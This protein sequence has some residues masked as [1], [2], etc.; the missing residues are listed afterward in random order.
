ML[1]CVASETEVIVIR[2]AKKLKRCLIALRKDLA[3][4]VFC[5][6]Q[7]LGLDCE[8]KPERRKTKS[9]PKPERSPVSV[10]QLSGPTLTL[11]I[12]T[13][14][15]FPEKKKDL[16]LSSLSELFLDDHV[17]KVGNCVAHDVKRLWID[18]ALT[19]RGF[20]DLNLLW[21][22]IWWQKIRVP[23]KANT[24]RSH[25]SLADMGKEY[26]DMTWPKKES[27]P[28]LSDWSV[29]VLSQ[30]QIM[31]AAAD[32]FASRKCFFAFCEHDVLPRYSRQELAQWLQENKG[33]NVGEQLKPLTS[34]Q[35]LEQ[36]NEKKLRKQERRNRR[37]RRR[38]G[39]KQ[40]SSA[41]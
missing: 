40:L 27:S 38:E 15:S 8:W 3:S 24:W 31:Y 23:G 37:R 12:Q 18:Y 21:N 5:G 22:W 2:D 26:L 1:E 41:S 29:D 17:L 30:E 33:Q 32:A 20:I 7:V 36:A 35:L 10:I 4:E 28:Q 13:P 6:H 14:R 34:K 11:V 9:E 25:P 19:I 39:R 16:L